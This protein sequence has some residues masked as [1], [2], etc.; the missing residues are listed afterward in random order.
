MLYGIL[1]DIL[2]LYGI[3][4][5]I[6]A[7]N[8]VRSL[9]TNT[10]GLAYEH[11]DMIG[12]MDRLSSNISDNQTLPPFFHG[13]GTTAKFDY[14]LALLE[15]KVYSSR[16]PLLIFV[17]TGAGRHVNILFPAAAAAAALMLEKNHPCG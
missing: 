6:A 4:P 12:G 5:D 10:L 11:V 16:T 2:M 1:L 9:Y 8:H 14:P 15:W 7:S 17:S 3:L 13:D